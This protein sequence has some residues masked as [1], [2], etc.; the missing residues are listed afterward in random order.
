[1]TSRRAG[2]VPRRANLAIAASLLAAN[3][4]ALFVVPAWLLPRG[5]AWAL[6]IVPAVLTSN[7]LWS[8]VHEAIHGMLLPD[9]GA[10]R[11]LGRLLAVVFGGAFDP[12]RVVHLMHHKHNRT[13]LERVEVIDPAK[14]KG[15]TYTTYYS[16]LLGGTFVTQLL[17]LLLLLVVPPALTAR[18]VARS[19]ARTYE[20]KAL[21]AM[22]TPAVLRAIR[23]DAAGVALLYG[24]AFALY[25]S[26]WGYL[27]A[28]LAV[29]ALLV[30]LVN[31]V[32]HYDTPLD[33]ALYARN[34]H[35]PRALSALFLHF[36]LHGV[37]HRHPAAPWTMLPG[38]FAGAWRG[39]Y[40][41]SLGAATVAQL[42]GPLAPEAVRS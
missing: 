17:G 10:S 23:V 31:Y 5:A 11:A 35:L 20:G 14:P 8:L 22:T 21:R 29:R 40:D 26:H 19:D 39:A 9:A 27:A 6:L 36:N 12:F 32:Y 33:D 28:A 1:M 34:L 24:T 41:G 7:T 4:L 25:G 18:I 15:R 42:R 16:N 30:S 38:L 2:S 37:H 3:A 13:P